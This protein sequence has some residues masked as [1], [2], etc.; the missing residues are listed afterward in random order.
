MD[1]T[2][3]SGEEIKNGKTILDDFFNGISN[4]P[5]VD[6]KLA[7]EMKKMYEEGKL[8]ST[9]LSNKLTSLREEEIND[10]N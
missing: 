10:K 7:P 3:K 9:N 6:K 2:V 8:T 5:D 4:I 1:K